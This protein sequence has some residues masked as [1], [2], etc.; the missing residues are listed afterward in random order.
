MGEL[1]KIDSAKLAELNAILGLNDKPQQST[2]RLPELK[3]STQRKDAEGN[4]IRQ[5]EGMLY[6]K[7]YEQAVYAKSVKIRVLSQLFQWI[8]YD[9]DENKVRNKTLLIPFMSH[10]AR[11]QRGGIRCGKPTSREMKDWSPD[12]KAQYKSITLFRQLRC[13]V[14]YTGTTVDGQE[15]TVEN[16]P[17][18]ILNKNSSYMN[19]EDEVVKKLNGR[20]YNDV[21]IDVHGE[22]HQ[23]G[24]VTYYT[25]HYTPDLKNPV[26]MDDKTFDTMIHFAEMVQKE[27]QAIDAAYERA[28]RE[29]S[30]D[31]D[32]IDALEDDLDSD[33]DD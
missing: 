25:W 5:F 17:A 2:N 11:D 23:N 10:E 27:N 7:N 19:F 14:T 12:R 21:W 4:D 9:P 1:Q 32:A 15:V 18:I 29:R 8:D 28:L 13:L 3:F 24:S 16:V 6:L 26:P 31:D 22:E 33:L 20:N 30:I